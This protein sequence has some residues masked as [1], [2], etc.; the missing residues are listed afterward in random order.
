MKKL[1]YLFGIL[2][3]FT[4]PLVFA[5]CSST[6]NIFSFTEDKIICGYC[7]YKDSNNSCDGSVNCTLSIYYSNMTLI[8]DNQT[9]DNLGDSSFIYN[10]TSLNFS[11]GDYIG[12]QCCSFDDYSGCATFNTQITPLPQLPGGG[13]GGSVYVLQQDFDNAMRDLNQGKNLIQDLKDVITRIAKW[14]YPNNYLVGLIITLSLI[15]IFI[16]S[17]EISKLLKKRKIRIRKEFK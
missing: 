7:K 17:Y 9:M 6:E 14:I 1:F 15:I 4:L 11:A 5:L 3:L 8:I 2:T 13:T 16:F 10:I 12:L